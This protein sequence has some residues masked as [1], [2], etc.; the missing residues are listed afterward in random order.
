[1]GRIDSDRIFPISRASDA[2]GNASAAWPDVSICVATRNRSRLLDEFLDRLAPD[3]FA[4]EVV[5][6]DNASTDATS[7]VLG[8]HAA[9][10]PRVRPLRIEEPGKSRALNVAASEAIGGL[11]AFTDD[12]VL[13]SGDWPRPLA[14]FIAE[15]PGFAAATGRVLP[16]PNADP[17]LVAEAESWRTHTFYDGGDRPREARTLLGGNMIIRRKAF[18]EAGGFDETLGPGAAGGYED[19]DLAARLLAAAMRIAYVPDAVVHH[20]ID[21][22]RLSWEFLRS[23]KSRAAASKFA[24]DPD[25][26]RRRA[27]RRILFDL[28]AYAARALVRAPSR[29][30][31]W[32]RLVEHGEVLRLA[33]SRPRARSGPLAIV[34]TNP[35]WGGGEK[36]MAETAEALAARGRP[37]LLVAREGSPLHE[38]FLR[39][40][41]NT[42]AASDL[43]TALAE[44]RPSLVLGNARKDLAAVKHA[45]PRGS[46]PGLVLLR[47]IARPLRDNFF[48]RRFWRSLTRIIVNSDSTGDI[49]R[50]SLPWFPRDRISRVYHFVPFEPLP[51]VP[52]TDGTFRIGVV[53]R[54]VPSK[55]IDQLV[56]ALALL[57]ADV[58]WSLVVAGDGKSRA[59]LESLVAERNLSG[60]CRFLGHV[61]DVHPVFARLDAVAIPSLYEGF[62]LT[63]VEAALAGLPVVASGVT[64]LREVVEDARTGLLVPPRDPPALAAALSC[65][66]RR[67]ALAAAMGR[68]ARARARQRFQDPSLVDDFVAALDRAAREEPV[69]EIPA[70]FRPA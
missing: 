69:R 30:R 47:N 10:S 59:G 16:P 11:L 42:V 49:V 33:R 24:A 45:M 23:Y 12:D 29:R 38:R 65:L 18:R 56:E 37:L 31:A 27:R 2:A 3:G 25:G 70:A 44:Q 67:P 50:E 34:N 53:S 60:R 46:R 9:A 32:G 68:A 61:R 54:L 17:A 62:C 51:P 52:A 58:R 64:A 40:V 28:A 19:G 7:A 48:R 26:A 43:R 15:R 57:P 55:A 8:R 13:P 39:S 36:W 4:R 6:V 20:R 14:Q 41:P 21:P 1:M 63:A 22:Q 66:A 35:S 5:V